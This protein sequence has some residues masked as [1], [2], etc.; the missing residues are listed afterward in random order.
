M[1][2]VRGGY[3]YEAQ[4]R[5]F[6]LM[7]DA[8][9]P[10]EVEDTVRSTIDISSAEAARAGALNPSGGPFCRQTPTLK[11]L[12]SLSLV[13]LVQAFFFGFVALHRFV[14]ADEGFFL[15]ASRLVLMHKKPY[16]DFLFEQAPLLPYVYA[17]HMKIFGISWA[18]TRMLAAV[19][20]AVLGTLVCEDVWRH[21]RRWAAAFAAVILFASSTLIF[22]YFPVVKTYSLAGLFLFASYVI[23]SRI[24]TT[25][26]GWAVAAGGL[27]LG[28][29]V[30]ARSYLLLVIPLFLWW[31]SNRSNRA[32]RPALMLWFLS[33]TAVALLPS[34]YLFL[35]SPSAFLFSNLKYH[36]LRSDGGLV[37]NWQ[38]K[39]IALLVTFVGAAESNGVQTSILFVV[40]LGFVFSIRR[41]GYRPRFAFQV[42][43]LVGIISLLPTPV[44]PQYFCLCI[45]LLLSAAVCVVCDL[46]ADVES[47]PGKLVAAV[48][49]LALVLVYVASS[50]NDFRRYLVTGDQVPGVDLSN[51]NQDWSLQRILAVSAAVDQVATPGEVVATC[52]PGFIFQTRAVPLPGQEADYGLMIADKLTPEQ[53][54]KYHVL[55]ASDLEADFAAHKPRV[56][57]LRNHIPA[58]GG[59]LWQQLL[60]TEDDFRSLLLAHDYKMVRSIGGISI[61]IGPK[62]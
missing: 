40:A 57:V 49:S 59:K 28:L 48:A 14:D 27:L 30:E 61:Y 2:H 58:K 56:V 6:W 42:A 39:V 44:H 4:G 46:I 5:P 36:A 21:T 47:R 62:S 32:N 10:S 60:Q 52:W 22:G 45:P 23:I 34:L 12:A 13:F 55:S 31:I 17:L 15:L 7:T 53:R 9:T 8:N 29:G 26:P 41:P 43:V 3:E 19:L 50:A 33:G 18:A 11:Y 16:L 51:D 1:T 25:T 54:A 38:E 24:S 20:T 35:S 37:G